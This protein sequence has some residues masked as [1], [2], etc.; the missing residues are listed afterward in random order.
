[1][2]IK[3]FIIFLLMT[4]LVMFGLSSCFSDKG[5]DKNH[6]P[7]N[8]LDWE[9]VYVG[10]IPWASERIDV[11]LRLYRDQ[12]FELEHEY[13]DRTDEPINYFPGSFQWDDTGNIITIDILCAPTQYKV[14]E[15]K[16]I[17]MDELGQAYNYVLKK[18]L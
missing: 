14:A 13:L 12:R 10:T 4:A 16:L 1:M 6:N 18:E 7:R 3:T 15:N 5:L 17:Q 8:S 11:R 2:K 9:G